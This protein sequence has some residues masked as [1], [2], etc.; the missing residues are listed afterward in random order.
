MSAYLSDPIKLIEDLRAKAWQSTRWKNTGKRPQDHV[1]HRA[2][3]KLEELVR[4]KDGS[5]PIKSVRE[6]FSRLLNL[7]HDQ[8]A[9]SWHEIQH[10]LSEVEKA[11]DD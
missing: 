10:C 1:C 9:Y 3:D 5:I 11:K 6:I 2:A 4:G 7:H 8:R